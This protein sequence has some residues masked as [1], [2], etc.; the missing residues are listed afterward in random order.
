MASKDNS[1]KVYIYRLTSDTGLAPCVDNGLFSLAVCKGGQIRNDKP[2]HTGLRWQIG[3]E[4]EYSKRPVFVLGTY[5][6]RLLYLARVTKV[7]TMKDYFFG[8]SVG[9]TD[10]IYSYKDGVLERNQ[11]L[12]KQEI[13]TETGRIVRDLAGEYVVLSDDYVYLGRD[14]VYVD[15]I[16]EF[17]PKFQETKTYTGD[18]AAEIIT[19]CEKYGDKKRHLPHEPLIPKCGG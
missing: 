18:I 11:H 6:G 1:P 17:F 3:S 9:R 13:H 16:K 7:V 2:V 19:V 10:D 15:E 4:N 8:M 12:R 5:K 14:A